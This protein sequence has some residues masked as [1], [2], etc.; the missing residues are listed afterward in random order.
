MM[1][2][3]PGLAPNPSP[4]TSPREP[5]ASNSSAAKQSAAL[6]SVLA[7][8]VITAAKLLTGILTGSLG[9]LSEAAHSFVD[10]VASAITFVS[11]RLADRP[12]DE[13][14]NY[15]HG[16]VESLSAFVETVLMLGSAVWIV[17]EAVRR[18]LLHE[19]LALNLS[20]WPF[21]VLLLSV[22][23]DISRSRRLAQ[24]AREHHSQALQADALHFRTDIFSSLAVLLGL[25]ATALGERLHLPGLERADPIA[26]LVVSVIILRLTWSLARQTIDTLLDATPTHH[27]DGSRANIRRDLFRELSHINGILDVNRIRIRQSGAGFFADLTL[28]LPRA[29]TFQRSEAI[30]A[31]ATAA[32]QHHLP[33]ADVVVHSIP[34]AAAAESLHD[35]VRAVAARANRS[36]HDLTLQQ[37]GNG[38]HL[39][40]HLE[41]SESMPLRE[42]HNLVTELEADIRHDI[43]EIRSILTHI[44]SEPATIEHPDSLDPDRALEQ[45]LR[46]LATTIPGLL[47]IHDIRVTRVPGSRSG[48][49]L[50]QISCHCTLDDD[51]PMSRVHELITELETAFKRKSPEVTRL[52]IHP[53][54]ATDNRR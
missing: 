22:A 21:V 51:L 23:V 30:T 18:L 4:R 28:S 42:A 27:P 33:G 15:G 52:L 16:K 26:A 20:P 10:L 43:P 39:E 34:V 3:S 29:L 9:M 13:D 11:I 24:T 37:H 46:R 25:A 31:A 17:Y 53:E 14:H 5:P 2:T 50:T 48:L 54:P 47:D 36:I 45:R 41:V 1:S 35:R 7:A 12:A 8:L 19:H 6:F 38:L 49:P 44:E 32:V 40:Q